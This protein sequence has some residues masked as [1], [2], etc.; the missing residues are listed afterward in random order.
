[1][2][3]EARTAR[4]LV[5]PS[6]AG[7][8]LD[9]VLSR[10]LDLSR[11]RIQ[12]LLAD[13]HVR[14]TGAGAPGPGRLRKAEPLQEGWVVEVHVPPAEAVTLVAQDL[15]LDIVYQDAH[16][17]VVDKAAG[18]VVHPA[19]GHREGTLVH[20]LLHH[21]TDL[22]GV[23]GRLRPGIVHRLDRDTSGL[24]VVAKTDAAHQ[25]LADALRR[26]HVKRRYRAASWGHL[27]ASPRTIDAP[28]ARDPRDRKKMAVVD[29]GRRALTRVRVRERWLAA[30]LLDV[31]LQTGR[32]H[33]IRV[34]LAHLGH[35]V[36]GDAVYGAGWERGMGGEARL[37]ARE[38]ARRVPRQFLH[39]AELVFDHPVTG[40]RMR[41]EAPL[42]PDL[43]AAA[44]WAR[45]TTSA[46][47]A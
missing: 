21:L 35:P 34:H 1:V 8:R 43:E 38:L 36:V 14:V 11:T 32:T 29:G 19:P 10:A 18:M 7:E 12:R 4:V 45:E 31:A 3:R 5:D 27:D 47:T 33:Q 23:G 17:A 28:V 15:P 24:L 39:A 37:W 41:F 26:R 25:G 16:L 13:G 6:E 9:V 2:T 22:S 44:R 46:G 20:A 30:E 40:E 42:P